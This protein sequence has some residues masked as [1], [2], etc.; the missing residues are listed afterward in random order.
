MNGGAGGVGAFDSSS[1]YEKSGIPLELSNYNAIPA[2]VRPSIDR[3]RSALNLNMM[4][5][6]SINESPGAG[7]HQ[8]AAFEIEFSD[9]T[10]GDEIGRGAYGVVF[11]GKWRG[12]NVALK[13]IQNVNRDE[14]AMEASLMKQIR[15]HS[16]VVQFLGVCDRPDC[17]VLVTEFVNQGSL[18][19]F[20]W[21]EKLESA[22]LKQILSGTAAGMYHLANE[23]IVHRDLAARNILLQKFAPDI[24]PK[25]TDFGMSRFVLQE[26]GTTATVTG[27]LKWMAPESLNSGSYS[28]K[29]D[30]WSF[31]VLMWEVLSRGETPYPTIDPVQASIKV[32]TRQLRLTPP[33]SA[34]QAVKDLMLLC[35][36]WEADQR[37]TFKQICNEMMAWD[38]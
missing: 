28:E 25:I 15:P 13:I 26:T 27:P 7:G 22:Q 36:S 10:F 35:F 12:G 4:T 14:V 6:N 9:L 37:P 2:S 18:V 24:V 1:H 3:S 11:K 8:L 38:F 5:R 33:E 16:N 19:N 17:L 29:S 20:L 31:G 32:A 30:V 23:G 34:P 21:T